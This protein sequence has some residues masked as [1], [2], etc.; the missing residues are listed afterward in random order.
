MKYT[1]RRYIAVVG[2]GDGRF[3]ETDTL[4]R[5]L[6]TLKVKLGPEQ[7][8]LRAGHPLPLDMTLKQ[9]DLYDVTLEVR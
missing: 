7:R 6:A 2:Y 9:L 4:K 8:V 1:P 5:V 3:A